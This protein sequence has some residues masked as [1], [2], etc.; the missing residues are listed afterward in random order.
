MNTTREPDALQIHLQRSEILA[1]MRNGQIL[2]HHLQQL[3]DTEVILPKL[4]ERDIP[5]KKS[6]LGQIIN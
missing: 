3:T 4:V 1:I 5:A 6:S 2:I